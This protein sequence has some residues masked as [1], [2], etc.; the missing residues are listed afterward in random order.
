MTN[1]RVVVGTETLVELE[2]SAP[3]LDPVGQNQIWFKW[4]FYNDDVFCDI[5][6]FDNYCFATAPIDGKKDGYTYTTYIA[7]KD[8]YNKD[9]VMIYLWI[10]FALSL[11][12]LLGD[13]W[14]SL[15]DFLLQCYYLYA[16]IVGWVGGN[17]HPFFEAYGGDVLIM[18]FWTHSLTWLITQVMK[19][20]KNFPILGPIINLVLILVIDTYITNL[21]AN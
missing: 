5:S 15:V 4:L 3:L 21:S 12:W 7:W 19:T 20:A 10:L 14:I 6:R 18:F 8:Y 13:P 11:F 9:V 16:E 2:F 17:N 1:S